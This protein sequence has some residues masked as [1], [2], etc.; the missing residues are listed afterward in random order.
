MRVDYVPSKIAHL[1]FNWQAIQKAL[2]PWV[3]DRLVIRHVPQQDADVFVRA[4]FL[5]HDTGEL[6]SGTA[7]QKVEANPDEPDV[8]IILA[9]EAALAT[10]TD[11]FAPQPP[12]APKPPTPKQ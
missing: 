1:D 5:H 7:R 3:P 4:S 9:V 8:P 12:A 11:S 2:W 10:I 6:R